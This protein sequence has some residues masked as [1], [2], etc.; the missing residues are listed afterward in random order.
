MIIA[1][2][3]IA[4]SVTNPA[5]RFRKATRRAS[6]TTIRRVTPQGTFKVR[7]AGE[8]SAILAAEAAKR[9]VK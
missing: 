4:N 8:R 6:V 9:G 7:T 1:P 5:P 2:H 3:G